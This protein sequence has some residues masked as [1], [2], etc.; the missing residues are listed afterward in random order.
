MEA[1]EGRERARAARNPFSPLDDF[2]TPTVLAILVKVEASGNKFSVASFDSSEQKQYLCARN[3]V[4]CSEYSSARGVTNCCSCV[5]MED[6]RITWPSRDCRV[7][8]SKFSFSR[9]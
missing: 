3:E 4:M 6:D 7:N 1:T 8:L 5:C 2:D 9:C